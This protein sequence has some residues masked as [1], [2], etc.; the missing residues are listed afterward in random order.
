L[1]NQPLTYIHLS[2]FQ[3]TLPYSQRC[4]VSGGC[5]SPLVPVIDNLVERTKA[6]QLVSASDVSQRRFWKWLIN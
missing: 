3:K 1:F 2:F 4:G 5:P 6:R